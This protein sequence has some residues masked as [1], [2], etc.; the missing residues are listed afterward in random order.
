[1][2]KGSDM[3]GYIHTVLEFVESIVLSDIHRYTGLP[4]AHRG[5]QRRGGGA[6][7]RS[8]SPSTVVVVLVVRLQ[9]A[10]HSFRTTGTARDHVHI[11][12]W[13]NLVCSINPSST[14]LK[15]ST[16]FNKP[17]LLR[18]RPHQGTYYILAYFSRKHENELAH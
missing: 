6:R 5:R 9:H 10:L 1:V 2:L 7:R 18:L 3:H 15:S 12:L 4:S 14:R 11:P 13:L 16:P 8:I 17:H